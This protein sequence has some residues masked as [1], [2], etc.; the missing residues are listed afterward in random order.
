MRITT[1]LLSA[2]LSYFGFC[3]ESLAG[4][5]PRPMRLR[6]LPAVEGARE[7]V[8]T[9]LNE[10]G[11]V[12]GQ[13][14][15]H[16]CLWTV[17]LV[18]VDLGTLGERYSRAEDVNEAG[19]VVGSSWDVGGLVRAFRWRDENANGRSDPGEMVFLA[20]IEGHVA[21]AANALNDEGQAV[22]YS[23]ELDGVTFGATLWQPDGEVVDLG[24]SLASSLAQD[25]TNTGVVLGISIEDARSFAWV[26]DGNAGRRALVGLEGTRV[27]IASINDSLQTAGNLV[28]TPVLWDAGA[29]R[30]LHEGLLPMGSIGDSARPRALNS[31]GHV[32]G[33][34]HYES[35]PRGRESA[36]FIWNDALGLVLLDDLI[37]ADAP[38]LTYAADVNGRGQIVGGVVSFNSRSAWMLAVP[39]HGEFRRGDSNGDEVLDLSDGINTLDWLFDAGGVPACL[40]AADVDDSGRIDIS[41]PIG[42]LAFLFLGADA[43]PNPGPLQCG[44]DPSEDELDCALPLCTP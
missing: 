22:G 27:R 21:S 9:G 10:Q 2:F 24:D 42:L 37:P 30:V 40:D 26:W 38:Q 39:Q 29:V 18:P 34:I 23:L 16:A 13:S 28:D 14:G 44:L 36:A 32:V 6:R 15:E 20:P 11:V 31:S 41:D 1:L 19:V 5:E 35:E 43:P 3:G 17:D 12:V 4:D 8:A 33:T 25:I 7:V